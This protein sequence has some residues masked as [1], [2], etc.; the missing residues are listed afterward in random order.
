MISRKILGLVVSGIMGLS[1]VMAACAPAATPTTPAAPTA[2]AA[3][4]TPV[5]DKP[6]REVVKPT[7]E[8]P[9]YGGTLTTL[10]SGD[11][12]RFDTIWGPPG[13][14][15]VTL[16]IEPLWS[17][18]WAKGPAGGY[19]TS[20][21]DW[22]LRG[23]DLF[24]YK[25]G[26]IAETTK[27]TID[28]S[29]A[30]GIITYQL[31]P[32]VRYALNPASEASRLVAGR[33]VTADDVIA[34]MKRTITDPA[35][36][37]YRTNPEIRVAQFTKT[38][39]REVTVKLPLDALVTAISRFGDSTGIQPQEVIQKYGN[40]DNW[41]NAVGTGAFQPTDYVAASQ[42][43]FT[44]NPN[45]WMKDP[46]G[47]GKGNQLPYLD[48]VRFLIVPDKSTQHAALRT[49]KLDT[50][51]A[52]YGLSWEDALQMRKTTPSLMEIEVPAQGGP[53]HIRIDK[54]PFNDVRV[55]R[56]MIMSIDLESIR[57]NL[58]GGL[59][60]INTFPF[61]YTKAYSPIYVDPSGP[62]VPASVKE[63]Y[64][65]NP[66]KAKQL[67]KEAGY[68]NGFKTSILLTASGADYYSIYKDMWAKVGIE[69]RLD[70]R[71]S[72]AISAI[73]NRNE[74]ESMSTSGWNPYGS[75][76]TL[77]T[78]YGEGYPNVSN[79]HDPFIDKSMANIRKAANTDIVE[80]MRLMR[81]LIKDYI[82]DQ[83]YAIPV[84]SAPTY[85]FWWP[86]VKNYSGEQFMGY[87]NI[88]WPQWVWIDQEMK[89]KMG[90]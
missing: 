88:R 35:A 64:V 7:S 2:P 59:G 53:T 75:F 12:T 38:G 29:K 1:L 31:R 86:W 85:S 80:S 30:E 49:G 52:G 11:I 50:L 55:R 24:A 20:E 9:K 4:T 5:E 61:N 87:I 48:S 18:D 19:G 51:F 22:T 45:Y 40:M 36:Y 34:H 90:Y 13:A 69:L 65:Y 43:V 73:L 70:I 47:P 27:W 16:A 60:Q 77:P 23:D 63:L 71:E 84:P 32:G 67:L 25:T 82:L 54:P 14:S 42:V 58:N 26:Y 83:V 57:K 62:D 10:V 79:I 46:I 56:A 37:F 21:T 74:H 44:R 41:K 68:P 17:G 78:F 6:Q 15:P 3:P 66:E 72:G 76:Y 89:K 81:V 28:E 33:E 8:A 39:P